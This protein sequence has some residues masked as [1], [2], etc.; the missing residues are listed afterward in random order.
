MPHLNRWV[1]TGLNIIL[2]TVEAIYYHLDKKKPA[3][4]F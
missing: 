4:Y 2:G 1:K 3:L